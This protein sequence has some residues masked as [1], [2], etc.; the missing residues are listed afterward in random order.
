MENHIIAAAKQNFHRNT[1]VPPLPITNSVLLWLNLTTWKVPFLKIHLSP[2]R[3]HMVPRK[4]LLALP[5]NVQI[6]AITKHA[7][8]QL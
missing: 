1:S 6:Q 5:L 4:A 2:Y 8:L 3:Q 7:D